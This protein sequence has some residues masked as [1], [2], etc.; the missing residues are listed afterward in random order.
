M[1]ARQP[2]PTR[3]PTVIADAN[4]LYARVLRDDLLYAAD[5]ELIAIAWSSRVLDEML[6]H[7]ITNV[8]GFSVESGERLVQAM[9]RAYPYATFDPADVH[10]ARVADL[11]LPDEDD[12]HVLA[13]AIASDAAIL[14]TANI[15]DFPGAVTAPLHLRVEAPDILLSGLIDTHP[16]AMYRVHG[17]CVRSLR[18]ATNA[19]TIEALR[20]A[21]AVNTARRMRLLLLLERLG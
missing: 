11:T 7:L 15:R 19:S 2:F 6:E 21:G 10:I 13:A 5:A 4:V 12:R 17:T 20:R 8:A 16:Q 14:C 18:G 1:T 3:I 9:Q